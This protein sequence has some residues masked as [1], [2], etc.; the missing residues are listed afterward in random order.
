MPMG[1][2]ACWVLA[3]A[4]SSI[5]AAEPKPAP[6]DVKPY[7]AELLVFA[8]ARGGTYVVR[9]GSEPHVFFST[10]KAFYEQVVIGRSADGDAWGISTWAP[11]VAKIQPGEVRR[12]QDGT[13]AKFCGDVE[14]GLTQLP[15]D[16]AKQILDKA[17]FL[18]TPLI[19]KPHLLGRDDSGVYY[20]VDMI[21]EQYGGKGF[22]VFIGKKG[23]MKQLPLSD[24][25]SDSA[26]E[27]F[28]T[29]TGDL[30]LVHDD[31]KTTAVWIRG[32]KK[33]ELVVLDPDANSSMIFKDL[34][35]YDFIGTICDDS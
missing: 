27:V 4:W 19:H 21:R 10:G 25:A 24:V 32:D 33:Q 8:D 11:R 31:A 35:V 17:T 26:G 29:K 28:S 16:K 14:T 15:A 1:A 20:Y 7:R 5:A 30:R 23:A 2:R 12:K 34:G 9:P 22:R 3:V 6:V 18:S 13:F